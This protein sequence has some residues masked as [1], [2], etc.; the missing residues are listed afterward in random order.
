MQ[1]EFSGDHSEA[2]LLLVC[3]SMRKNSVTAG[4]IT[5][6]QRTTQFGIHSD[7][8]PP[9]ALIVGDSVAGLFADRRAGGAVNINCPCR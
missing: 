2:V 5:T 4:R 7:A 9:Y 3:G 1:Y 6:T 8:M